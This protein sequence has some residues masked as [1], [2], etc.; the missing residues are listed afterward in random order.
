VAE[1]VIYIATGK[2]RDVDVDLD[3]VLEEYLP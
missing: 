1:R 2:V 3:D